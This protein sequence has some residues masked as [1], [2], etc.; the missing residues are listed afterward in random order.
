MARRSIAIELFYTA[1]QEEKYFHTGFLRKPTGIN[2]EILATWL[3]PLADKVLL[4]LPA[5]FVERNHVKVPYVIQRSIP[6]TE[7][8]SVLTLKGIS[9]KTEAYW[10]RN[11]PLFLPLPLQPTEESSAELAA[12][13]GYVV[14][15]Q[16]LGQLGKVESIHCMRNKYVVSLTYKGKELL[17]PYEAPFLVD[18]NDKQQTI[19]VALPEDYLTVML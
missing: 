19:T 18:V 11:L 4:Q 12:I 7:K 14:E 17:I 9:S 1:I 16:L 3:Y 15:D 13:V 10:L 2:G 6:L 5:L 8:Q